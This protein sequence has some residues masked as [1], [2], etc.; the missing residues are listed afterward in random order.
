MSSSPDILTIYQVLLIMPLIIFFLHIVFK[1]YELSENITT[2]LSSGL[3]ISVASMFYG[4]GALL[5]VFLWIIFLIFRILSWRE[6]MVSVISFAVP[7][8][9][10][11]AYYLWTADMSAVF[12][13]YADFYSKLFIST[14]KTDIFQF[15]IWGIIIV[16]LI[17]PAFVKI[18]STLG[19]YNIN[20]RK[21]MSV[22]AW[23][24]IF[25]GLLIFS[26]GSLVFNTLIFLPATII[27]GHYLSITKKSV[28]NEVLILLV[29]L[30][31][32][33]HNFI[34]H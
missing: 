2:V 1:M 29:L 26:N 24:V 5:L 30:L 10:L 28:L 11:L 13:A 6:W 33:V 19:S 7:Y 8:L 32:V 4:Q 18:L 12:S 34:A 22:A 16:F 3:L 23:L 25:S 14:Y 27:T 20:F 15:I 21:K 17:L 9:Y 31:E